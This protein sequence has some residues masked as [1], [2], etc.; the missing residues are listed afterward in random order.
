[1]PNAWFPVNSA[2]PVRDQSEAASLP[3]IRSRRIE[4]ADIPAIAALLA[5]GF[6]ARSA[7]F[8]SAVFGRLRERQAPPGLPQYGYLL[9]TGAGTAVGAILLIFSAHPS[10]GGT[11]IR[12]NVSSWFV[13]PTFRGYASLLVSKALGHRSVTYLNITPA[14]HTLPLLRAQGYSLYCKGVFV[15]LPALRLGPRRACVTAVNA[16]SDRPAALDDFES[17]LLRDHARYGCISLVCH[18][19]NQTYPFVFRPR[20]H[21]GIPC[22]QLVYCRSLDQFVRFAGPLG[23]YLA[24]RG[25]APVIIDSNAPIPGLIGRFF[26]GRMPKYFKGP[27]RPPL[28]DLAYTET[29]MF[30]M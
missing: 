1:M 2:F 19:A 26:D 4:E 29:A 28:C 11:G 12:C 6:P 27:S 25:R 16:N 18:A 30:G 24:V 17:G 20:V 10:S 9:E 23:R 14:P 15:A 7:R 5:R 22:A 8:W 3:A 21:K 13:E